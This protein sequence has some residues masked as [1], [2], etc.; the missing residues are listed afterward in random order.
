TGQRQGSDKAATRQ[1]RGSDRISDRAATESAT[2]QR[3]GRDGAATVAGAGGLKKSP[4][5][6][7]VKNSFRCG[8]YFLQFS[9]LKLVN[10][11]KKN[12]VFTGYN[13][14]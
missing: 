13:S 7:L 8:E 6:G 1:R 9:R 10:F 2:G 3:R 4:F 11:F 14:I 12:S 5:S